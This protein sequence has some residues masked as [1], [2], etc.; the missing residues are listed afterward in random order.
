MNNAIDQGRSQKFAKG[1]AGQQKK[2]LVWRI[3]FLA[4]YAPPDILCPRGVPGHLRHPPGYA[5][6]ID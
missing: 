3:I 1:G 6:A 4:L 5:P 2:F